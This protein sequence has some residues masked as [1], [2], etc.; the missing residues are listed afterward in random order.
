MKRDLFHYFESDVKS[1]YETYVKAAKE[2]FGKDCSATPYH[3]VSFGLN[4]SFKYNMNGGACHVHFI[5]YKTGTAVGIRYTIA[6]VFGAR[7]EAHDSDMLNYV[8]RELG[9]EATGIN[10][11][12]EEFMKDSN[13]I[14]DEGLKSS[15]AN[16]Q[17]QSNEGVSSADEIKKFKELLD[18]GVITQEEFDTKK[19]Q[20]LGI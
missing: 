8:E 18:S 3:T 6:Q 20:L 19:K 12:M 4:Y 9:V 11:D 2:K 7:Y 16:T 15:K 1:V 10:I 17:T 5:P 14:F 13:R